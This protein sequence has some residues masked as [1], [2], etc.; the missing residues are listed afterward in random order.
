MKPA[1]VSS[2]VLNENTSIFGLFAPGTHTLREL[3]ARFRPPLSRAVV[4]GETQVVFPLGRGG[5]GGAGRE[6]SWVR[7]R[8]DGTDSFSGP[9]R[10]NPGFTREAPGP[11]GRGANQEGAHLLA[12][13]WGVTARQT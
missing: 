10:V 1:R 3:H 11:R 9:E 4:E 6:R 13:G 2:W 7:E 8:S 12:E 5:V